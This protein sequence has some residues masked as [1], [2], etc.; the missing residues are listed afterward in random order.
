VS[1]D[2]SPTARGRAAGRGAAAVVGLL[3]AAVA[4]GAAELVAGLVR[5]T[6]VIVSLGETVIELTPQVVTEFVISQLGGLDRGLLLSSVVVVVAL[7][8][9]AIGLLARRDLRLGTGA[10]VL[11][12]VLAALASAANPADPLVRSLLPGLAAIPAGVV[13]LRM[14]LRR[15]SAPGNRPAPDGA[16]AATSSRRD[17]L[18]VA[19]TLSVAAAAGVAG[20]R[21]LQARASALRER[22]EL[23]LPSAD[24]PA[25]PPPPGADFEL[26]G[27]SPHLTPNEAFFRIDTAAAVPNV[28]AEEWQL[29]I[30]GMVDREV[31]LTYAD[32]LERELVEEDVTLTC[33]S[34]EVGGRLVGNARWLG[35]RLDDLLREAGIQDGADQVVGRSVDGFTAGFPV[36]VALDGRDA[37]LA[38][39]MNGEPLPLEHG[40]PVRIVV[41][42]LYG[43]VSAVKW[44][45]E[46]EV[47]T[48]EA[49]DAYWIRR[50]WAREGPVK[51][52]SRI[53]R[54]DDRGTV[55]AGE[56]VVAGVAWAQTRGIDR[57]EVQ[58]DDGD[59][60]EA[61]LAD[62]DGERD[63]WR[64]W[65]VAWDAE[66]G[67]HRLRVRAT[68]GEGET[69]PED[70]VEPIPDGAEGWHTVTVEVA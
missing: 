6:S 5:V 13:A 14:G 24:R 27:L 51:T 12:G 32:L 56:V 58:V 37:L 20:G 9:L 1:D 7:L 69:Q 25:P 41:P 8:S 16:G 38:I 54:P 45:A 36:E 40:Y 11:L 52:Q 49:F 46:L 4:V 30:H 22:L 19:G 29:R 55:A 66:P 67:R 33:V 62:L 50:N 23:V 28:R 61:E 34:N 70:E 10:V 63:T 44:V 2:P 65:R 59:W 60:R 15:L 39:G 31:T 43:Y 18:R 35:V 42:G 21:W 68:D 53:D 3:A 48:F 26:D 57:V 17:F 64:Q 47:T